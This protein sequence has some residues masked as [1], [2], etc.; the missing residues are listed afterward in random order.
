MMVP[1]G[2]GEL[3]VSMPM[4]RNLSVTARHLAR[5]SSFAS[6]TTPMDRSPGRLTSDLIERMEIVDGRVCPRFRNR[7]IVACARRVSE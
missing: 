4:L 1:F 5:K 6:T 2:S 3:G 7:A